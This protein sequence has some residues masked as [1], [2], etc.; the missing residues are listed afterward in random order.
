MKL[1]AVSDFKWNNIFNLSL[2]QEI[3]ETNAELVHLKNHI[4]CNPV[5]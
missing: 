2:V 1:L 5:K 3:L 4:H